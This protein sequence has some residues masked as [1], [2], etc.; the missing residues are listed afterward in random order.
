[1]AG[2]GAPDVAMTTIDRSIVGMLQRLGWHG[3]AVLMLRARLRFARSP[4]REALL[5]RL[6]LLLD[7]LGR[8]AEAAS[9]YAQAM[10]GALAPC[11]QRGRAGS[12]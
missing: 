9:C 1:M 4:E 6:A 5:Y 10:E 3:L 12:S 2:R 7:G 11:L 8:R